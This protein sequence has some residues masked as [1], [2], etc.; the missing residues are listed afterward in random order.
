MKHA[1]GEAPGLVPSRSPLEP[2]PPG[3]LV[4]LPC[5]R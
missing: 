2:D 3:S 4:K 5:Q 1:Y